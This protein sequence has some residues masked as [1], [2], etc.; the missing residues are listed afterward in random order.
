MP[1]RGVRGRS[2]RAF[3]GSRS[4]P[5]LLRRAEA[6]AARPCPPGGVLP[7]VRLRGLS[8]VPGLGAPRGCRCPSRHGPSR[9]CRCPPCSRGRPRGRAGQ[10]AAAAPGPRAPP[11]A[12]DG[13]PAADPAEAQPA[14]G[15]GR[16]ARRGPARTSPGTGPPR[17]PL[18]RPPTARPRPGSLGAPPTGWPGRTRSSRPRPRLRGTPPPVDDLDDGRPATAGDGRGTA[19]PAAVASVAAPTTPAAGAGGRDQVHR[20]PAQD[21]SEVFGPAWERPRRYE[22]YPTLKTRVGLPPSMGRIPRLGVAVIALAARRHRPVLRG[23]DAPGHRWQG[24]RGWH[25][26]GD[27]QPRP[28]PG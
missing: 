7:L 10:H 27:V 3:A 23:P 12:R 24:R 16:A 11:C 19:A 28:W 1:L 14:A 20:P 5:P 18:P 26:E 13:H 9:H 22:A 4:P 17:R 2:R 6:G 25:H 8:H 21:P 15:V